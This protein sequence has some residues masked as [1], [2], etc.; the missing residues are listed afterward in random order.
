MIVYKAFLKL[1][2]RKKFI[3]IAI[4]GVFLAISI[5][6]SSQVTETLS[7][8]DVSLNIGLVDHSDSPL[9]RDLISYLEESNKVTVVDEDETEL[10]RGIF[11]NR[12]Y[13]TMEIYEDLERNVLEGKEAIDIIKNRESAYAFFG[14]LQAQKFLMFAKATYEN[15]KFDTDK[16]LTALKSESEVSF[17]EEGIQAD[18]NYLRFY[19]NS[20]A[21]ISSMLTFLAVGM[22][23]ADFGDE[24]LQM[25]NN[26]SGKSAISFQRELLLGQLTLIVVSL[27]PVM[28]YPIISGDANL[29]FYLR[30]IGLFVLNISLLCLAIIS[31]FNFVFSLTKKHSALA[32]IGNVFSLGFGFISGSM[33]PRE[34][35]PDFSLFVARFYP[36]YYFININNAFFEADFKF[37]DIL[38]DLLVQVGFIVGFFFLALLVNRLKQKQWRIQTSS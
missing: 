19:F 6:I 21:Y 1:T 25:R 4:V 29:D 32:A 30:N 12:Y 18:Q 10:K 14:E 34:L 13:V 35:L 5:L 27:L 24:Q 33:V 37:K 3:I 22:V 7:F 31:I 16:V 8:E 20:A 36:I 15:G 23:M 9:S 2:W 11:N 38:P 28:L 17:L 26:V